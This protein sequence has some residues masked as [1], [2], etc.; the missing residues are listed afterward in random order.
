MVLTINANKTINLDEVEVSNLVADLSE[1]ATQIDRTLSACN[2]EP[3]K[4]EVQ[5]LL[6]KLSLLAEVYG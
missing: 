5:A 6:S 1:F 3:S 4:E 2:E